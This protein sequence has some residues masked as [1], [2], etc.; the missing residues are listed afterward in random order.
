MGVT[1]VVNQKGGVGK[2]TVTLGLAAAAAADGRTVLV[3]DLDPQANATTGLG[4][5]DAESTVDQ[6]LES[7]RAGSLR[8][9][10]R[11]SGWTELVGRVDLAPSSPRLAQREHQL[12][13]DVIGAQDRL[14]VAL[15]GLAADYDEVLVDCP[16]S[17]GLL[18]VNALFAADRVVIVAEPAAWSSDGVQQI[19]RNVE[20]IAERRSGRPEVAGIVV[21]RLARTRDAAYWDRELRHLHPGSVLD[22]SVRLRAAVAEAAAQS[23]PVHALT[24]DGAA[25]AAHE[26]DRLA[27]RL[28]LVSAPATTRTATSDAT[29]GGPPVATQP[30]ATT[31]GSSPTE[32]SATEQTID[33]GAHRG[34]QPG[35]DR[36]T[37][38]GGGHPMRVDAEPVPAVSAQLASVPTIPGER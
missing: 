4:V 29:P 37:G 38:T 35:A 12:A 15:E 32:P 3:V 20:R 16:P 25:D 22:P 7:E 23:Q 18:T 19:L 14:A 13:M 1:A 24:R 34:V 17:L 11:A 10:V 33:L 28:G 9:V 8:A 36:S 5:F 2:T 30:T 21:N 6:A 27:R 26:F 31:D